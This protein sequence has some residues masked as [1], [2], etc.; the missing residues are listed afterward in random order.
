MSQ[1]IRNLDYVILLCQDLRRMR[2]FYHDPLGFPTYREMEGWIELRVGAV[3]LT[4]R[5]RGRPYE[6]INRSGPNQALHLT[7][8]APSPLEV[9]SHLS[10]PGR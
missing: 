7:R 3:L 9:H 2:S 8:P 10:G 1:A 4:L 6:G 5:E